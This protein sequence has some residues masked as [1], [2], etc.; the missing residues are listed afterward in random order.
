M[1]TTRPAREGE[2]GERGALRRDGPRPGLPREGLGVALL[3]ALHAALAVWGAARNSVTFDENFHLPA[4]VAIVACGDWTASVAQPP[5]VKTLC[6]LPALALGARPP[7]RAALAQGDEMTAGESFM[8]ANAGRYYALFFAARMVVVTLSV[9]LGLLVWWWAR[10]LSGT[11]GGLLTLAL[12]ALAPEALAHAGL[13]GMDLAT[14]L[15]FTAVLAAFWRF[16]AT[17]TWRWWLWTALAVAAAFLTR[18][19]A[20][21]LVPIL[22]LLAAIGTVARRLA[23]P[24][25]VW[26]GLVLLAPV[27]VLALDLGYGWHVWT[28]PWAALP[29]RSE[30]FRHLAQIWPALRFPLPTEYLGGLDYIALISQAGGTH[31]YLLGRILGAGPWYYFPLALLFKWPLGFLGVVALTIAASA[32]R[33]DARRDRWD[34]AFLLLPAAAMLGAAMLAST[35]GVGIRYLFPLLPLL[36]V[37]AGGLM[38]ESRQALR[39]SWWARGAVALALLQAIETG[40]AAPWYLSFFNW[41]AGGPG[42]GY[43]LVND[44]NVDWGQGL[45]ALRDE[46]RKRGIERIHLAYHGTT[47]PAVYGIDYVPY[48]GGTPGPES[49]WLA[50]SSYYF[51]GLYQRMVTPRGRTPTIHL[52]FARL[53]DVPP[54]A[55]LGGSIYLYRTSASGGR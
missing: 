4:G 16:C 20:V 12:Y 14:G 44:S 31:T 3:L 47:D 25:R 32:A 10:R 55:R 40:L 50:V 54:E 9:L 11:R 6:A 22:V 45:I 39:T 2:R 29:F 24:G 42:G 19:S 38:I 51:V 15:A 27:V 5:L 17:G 41:P 18:F 34:E 53:W 35:L 23:R 1:S 30:A 13:V 37:W 7:S 49:E 52:D 43:R 26:L 36:C 46:M 8:R 48:L 33:R 28:G 21:Q